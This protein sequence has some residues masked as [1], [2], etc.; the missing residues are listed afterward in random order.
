M[1]FEGLAVAAG[2]EGYYRPVDCTEGR[3]SLGVEKRQDVGAY[4]ILCTL[5][6][7]WA[8]PPEL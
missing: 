5:A 1:H 8:G 4:L 6:E 3:I 2:E 7:S